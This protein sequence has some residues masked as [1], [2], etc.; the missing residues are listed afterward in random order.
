MGALNNSSG[1]QWFHAA[2]LTIGGLS[3]A[4]F[5]I[6]VLAALPHALLP[7][8]SAPESGCVAALV[9]TQQGRISKNWPNLTARAVAA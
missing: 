3:I 9:Q 6:A 5:L 4:N 8:V 7:V 2:W 1:R